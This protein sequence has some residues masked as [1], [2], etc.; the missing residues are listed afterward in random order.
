MTVAVAESRPLPLWWLLPLWVVI[1]LNLWNISR[2]D[3]A[4]TALPAHVS[5]DVIASTQ[6]VPWTLFH[7]LFDFPVVRHK[8]IVVP[9]VPGHRAMRIEVEK[10]GH[11]PYNL[12]VHTDTLKPIKRGDRLEGRVWARLDR[13]PG[14]R[15]AGDITVRLQNARAPYKPMNEL[16]LIL[17]P[18]WQEFTVTA[19]A[20]HDFAAGE[21]N[22]VLYLASNA[23][24]VD[25]GPAVI[26]NR[27]QD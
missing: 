22:M 23:Q 15:E 9:A 21:A 19:T 7:N 10:S 26:Y 5:P 3:D 14:G 1:C 20:P 18:R 27:G 16:H 13:A 25:I 6:T 17:T 24:T 8:D 12:L 4:P 2:D 11:D